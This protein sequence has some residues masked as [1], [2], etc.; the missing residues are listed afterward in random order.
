MKAFWNPCDGRHDATKK[1]HNLQLSHFDTRPQ[2]QCR[3]ASWRCRPSRPSTGWASRRQ[4]Y[5]QF[6]DFYSFD[7]QMNDLSGEDLASRRKASGQFVGSCGRVTNQ[8][9]LQVVPTW[10]TSWVAL[11]LNNS[12]QR[13]IPPQLNLFQNGLFD[14]PHD[15]I[16]YHVAC[17]ALDRLSL[18]CTGSQVPSLQLENRQASLTCPYTY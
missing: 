14:E 8:R 4:T 2:F 9:A 18:N 13:F 12:L 17:R 16:G 3:E 5:S 1:A 7:P 11:A 15:V 10:Q 6:W